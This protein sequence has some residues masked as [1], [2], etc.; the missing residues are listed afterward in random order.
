[1]LEGWLNYTGYIFDVLWLTNYS[2][3]LNF[4]IAPT[5]F[6][7]SVTQLNPK[8]SKWWWLHFIPTLLWL[9][10]CLLFFALAEEFKYNDNISAMGLSVPMLELT[11]PNTSD[12]LGL[13]NYINVAT[14]AHIFTYILVILYLLFSTAKKKGEKLLSTK[15]ETL[16]PLRN[17]IYHFVVVTLILLVVKWRFQSDVGDYLI[18]LYVTFMI[19][20]TTYQ[21]INSSDYFSQTSS[22]LEGPIAKY[23][24]SSLVDDHKEVILEAIIDQLKNEKYHLNSTASLSGLSKAIHQTTHHVSQ[25]INEKLN[26]SFFEL[27]AQYRVEEAK[28][29]LKTDLGKNLTIEEIAERVGYNSKS[30]FN[31][32]FKKFTSQTPSQFRDS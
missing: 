2:E 9:L 27:I 17:S 26:Q 22:I 5:I 12:P 21:V 11:E 32:A 1:M 4:A 18:F 6:L 20:L 30:A 25:V 7:F 24:K 31:S 23:K 10:Y 8:Q 28:S 13:R 14:I 3:P 16:A 19:V 15:H 29:I